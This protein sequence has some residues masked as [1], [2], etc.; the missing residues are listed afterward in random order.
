[1]IFAPGINPMKGQGMSRTGKRKPISG[2]GPKTNSQTGGSSKARMA[3]RV[4]LN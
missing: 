2:Y 4:I 1:M 3:S